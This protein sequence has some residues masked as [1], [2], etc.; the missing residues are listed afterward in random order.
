M[1]IGW[2]AMADTKPRYRYLV[3][4]LAIA[5]AATIVG[6][7]VW[8]YANASA[9][10]ATPT[11]TATDLLDENGNPTNSFVCDIATNCGERPLVPSPTQTDN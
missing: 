4:L 1:T 8:S 2:H 9:S 11:P 5:L 10:V 7:L 6:A 3:T